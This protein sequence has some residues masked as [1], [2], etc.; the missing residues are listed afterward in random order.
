MVGDSGFEPET[1][2]LSGAKAKTDILTGGQLSSFL[3]L[4]LFFRLVAFSFTNID[5]ID[6]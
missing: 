1:P 6:N 5:N 3:L 4:F 2:V